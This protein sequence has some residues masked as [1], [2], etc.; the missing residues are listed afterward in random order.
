MEW[1]EL[2]EPTRSTLEESIS[3]CAFVA[4]D[5]IGADLEA[6]GWQECLLVRSVQTLKSE[7]EQE[8]IIANEDLPLIPCGAT[9]ADEAAPRRRCR[10][11]RRV[12]PA[13]FVIVGKRPRSK[14]KRV[15]VNALIAGGAGCGGGTSSASSSSVVIDEEDFVPPPPPYPRQARP[16][17][18]SSPPPL[19]RTPMAP[20]RVPSACFDPDSLILF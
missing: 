4:A 9:S 5:E 15:S 2:T 3:S 12:P 7:A 20:P 14:R 16:P 18:L 10:R 13:E 1:I 19:S 11:G 6:L 17:P 8:Y